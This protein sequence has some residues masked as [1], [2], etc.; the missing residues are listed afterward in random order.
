MKLF[1]H[2]FR[3]HFCFYTA[4]FTYGLYV[5]WDVSLT[6]FFVHCTLLYMCILRYHLCNRQGFAFPE[7]LRVPVVKCSNNKRTRNYIICYHWLSICTSRRNAK[8]Y[9][10]VFIV[11]GAVW[12]NIR[13]YRS[14]WDE[15]I[16]STKI[17]F[18][19]YYCLFTLN[20]DIISF[21]V[22]PFY[23]HC[24][25]LEIVKFPEY[26]TFN[27]F[28]CYVASVTTLVK[29]TNFKE[30]FDRILVQFLSRLG[31][32]VMIRHKNYWYEISLSVPNRVK[33]NSNTKSLKRS[34]NHNTSETKNNLWYIAVTYVLC[35]VLCKKECVGLRLTR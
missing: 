18:Y 25:C 28:K 33:P 14:K 21:Y 13:F 6:D 29:T 30:G 20:Y 12:T 19:G 11:C 16:I 9:V 26:F 34:W 24:T 17:Q 31:S 5:L 35:N 7:H 3:W 27:R 10:R 8:T 22:Y 15:V 4:S 23:A 2:C 32:P 1:P